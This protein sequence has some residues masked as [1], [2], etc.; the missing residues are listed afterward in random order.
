ML[1]CEVFLSDAERVLISVTSGKRGEKITFQAT[2]WYFSPVN[3][4][5]FYTRTCMR[6]KENKQKNQSS[7]WWC[8]NFQEIFFTL[9]NLGINH[10]SKNF[11]T[12]YIFYFQ[13]HSVSIFVITSFVKMINSYWIEC[14]RVKGRKNTLVRMCPS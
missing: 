3:D 10:E 12:L 5:L 6:I 8:I 11:F 13:V 1:L 7:T 14:E 9:E 4:F 2:N